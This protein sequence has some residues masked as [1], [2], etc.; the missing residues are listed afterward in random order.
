MNDYCER[1]VYN[2]I[3]LKNIEESE[4]RNEEAG[5]QRMCLEYEDVKNIHNKRKEY[6]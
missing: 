5:Y 3:A 2:I 4:E 6:K 1:K